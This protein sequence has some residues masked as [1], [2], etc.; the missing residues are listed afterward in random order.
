MVSTALLSPAFAH[1]LARECAAGGAPVVV[2]M[3]GGIYGPGDTSQLGDQIRA[4]MAGKLR[5]VSFPTLG[6][7]AG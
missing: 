3:P 6:L 5:H 2:A 1:E 4:A 7:N